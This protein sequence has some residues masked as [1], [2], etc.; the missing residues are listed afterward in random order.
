MKTKALF[1]LGLCGLALSNTRSYSQFQPLIASPA[2]ALY[3]EAAFYLEQY[4]F[5][6]SSADFPSLTEQYRLQLENA[7]Q[8]QA[9]NCSFDTARPY[10]QQ[11]I[12]SLG[13]GHS[14]YVS[15]SAFK[16][17]LSSF[18]GMNP[19]PN[20]S[21][22]FTPGSANNRG[23]VLVLE[24]NAG[25]P[26]LEAGIQP[27]DRITGVNGVKFQATSA[28]NALY[29]SLNTDNSVR[30]S[31]ARGDVNKPVLLEIN[32]KRRYTPNLNL[33]FS[34]NAAGH[35]GVVV[36]RFPNFIGFNDIG[37]KTHQLV[38]D[39]IANKAKAVVIDLRGNIGGEETECSSAAAAF[40]A[41]GVEFMG[42]T[43]YLKLP[44]GF[45]DGK[46]TGNDPRDLRSFSIPDPQLWKGK[47]AVLVNRSTASCGEIFAYV[48]QRA[49]R[50]KVIGETTLGVLN[51]ATDYFSLIDQSAVAI[52]YS[53]TFNL[54]GSPLSERITPDV[55]LEFNTGKIGKTGKDEM[56]EKALQGMG[57]K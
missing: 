29:S 22:G 27:F 14:Y 26:A 21:F 33:P 30:L 40:I 43:K 55:K 49:K 51:T 36:M 25:T 15:Q 9:A 34:Y 4:Y 46:T 6:Y 31:V 41:G 23:E 45:K 2:T 54:D 11:L 13:D 53:R 32:F 47:M 5:G 50:G 18:T 20:P 10:I 12:S 8:L 1:V 56:L 7:C 16:S 39:A 42:Q 17:A 44:W 3:K 28:I 37:P 57:V 35:P 19:N 48:V 24:V 38:K 52:T